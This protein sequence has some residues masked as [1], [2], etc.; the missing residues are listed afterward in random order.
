[1]QSLAD[2]LLSDDDRLDIH[3]EARRVLLNAHEQLDSQRSSIYDRINSYIKNHGLAD[4]LSQLRETSPDVHEYIEY[5]KK[6][7][8]DI[9]CPTCSMAKSAGANAAGAANAAD[10][11]NA[12]GAG[13]AVDLDK[14]KK[15]LIELAKKYQETRDKFVAEF[16]DLSIQFTRL[17]AEINLGGKTIGITADDLLK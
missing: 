14:L 16:K 8:T 7:A 12:A 10:A 17:E 11:A 5:L 4:K 3:K 9:W 6:L 2:D 15:K 13:A 1:M